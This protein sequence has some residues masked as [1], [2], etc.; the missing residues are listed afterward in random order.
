MKLRVSVMAFLPSVACLLL[1]A[2][3]ANCLHITQHQGCRE[4]HRN[5]TGHSEAGSSCTADL[6]GCHGPNGDAKGRR[7]YYGWHILSRLHFGA[8]SKSGLPS[9]GTFPKTRISRHGWTCLVTPGCLLGSIDGSARRD[10]L[11]VVHQDFFSFVSTRR[12]QR[13]PSVF[14]GITGHSGISKSAER[15]LP[16]ETEMRECHG[17]GGQATA[18]RGR[19]FATT[20]AIPF[21]P[22]DFTRFRSS[23]APRTRDLYRIFMIGL[24]ARRCRPG[25]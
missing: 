6:H 20:R 7:P 1:T 12:S 23:A 11:V 22:Y 19:H 18:P 21:S 16:K 15:T 3:A 13:S 9:Q 2:P 24:T 5:L 14:R 10:F 8:S 25:V 4:S 17:T